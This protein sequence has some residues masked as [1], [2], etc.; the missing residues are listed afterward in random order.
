M[1]QKFLLINEEHDT[2]LKGLLAFGPFPPRKLKPIFLFE[3][4]VDGTLVASRVNHELLS[5]YEGGDANVWLSTCNQPAEIVDKSSF[6]ICQAGNKFHKMVY[7][8]LE[9]YHLI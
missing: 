4:V 9:R 3:V 8:P 1:D 2:L 6:E 5:D 7:D